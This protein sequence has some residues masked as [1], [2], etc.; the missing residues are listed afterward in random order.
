MN[1]TILVKDVK[2]I[3]YWIP[4]GQEINLDDGSIV[5]LYRCMTCTKVKRQ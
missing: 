3:H 1:E 2:H 5:Y 4:T